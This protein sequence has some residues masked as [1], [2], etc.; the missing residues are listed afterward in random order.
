MCPFNLAYIYSKETLPSCSKSSSIAWFPMLFYTTIYIGDLYKRSL[1]APT[2]TTDQQQQQQ[3]QTIII[4]D[5]AT[6]LGSRALFYSSLLSLIVSVVLPAFVAEA[7]TG[8]NQKKQNSSSWWWKRVCRV[9]K[10]MQIDLVTIWA[11]S[12]LVF[13]GC[14]FATLCVFF[15]FFFFGL[16]YIY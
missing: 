6:R 12:Q 1:P 3:Q 16:K 2:T 14:M 5:E 10:G 8:Q 7:A 13:A 4:N 11:T 9:P 15:F